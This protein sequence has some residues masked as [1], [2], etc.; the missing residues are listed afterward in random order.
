M[1]ESLTKFVFLNH[2]I[3]GEIIQVNKVFEEFTIHKNYPQPVKKLLGE[4][5]IATNLMAATLKF[6]GKIT[7]QIQGNG[8]LNL[9]VI[10]TTNNFINKGTARYDKKLIKKEMS[11]KQLLGD[12]QLVVSIEP[13]KGEK[14]QGVIALDK[15]SLS[16]CIKQ[17]FL[18]SEQI[19]TDL[20]IRVDANINNLAGILLQKLP[21]N[22]D[23]DITTDL[24][25]FEHVLT[26]AN[27]IK[28]DELFELSP[29]DILYRLFNQEKV[30]VFEP[31]VISF[32]CGCSQD[33]SDTVV[34][35]LGLEEANKILSEQGKI[36]IICEYC[37]K[38]YYFNKD[39]IEQ[40]FISH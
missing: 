34:R 2:Q 36:S 9:A 16:D 24:N 25:S 40:L 26:L 10:N 39:K 37:G 33:K 7:T 4:L 38:E 6:N 14:Y 32:N 13:D 29:N 31:E 35:S 5:F 1:Q 17:Y 3:K 12:A 20:I 19:D 28:N 15:D 23:S 11:F 21:S 8:P 18:Q 30:K 22:S 27:T